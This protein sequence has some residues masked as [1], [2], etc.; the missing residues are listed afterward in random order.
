[1]ARLNGILETALDVDDLGATVDFYHG[2]LGLEV[3]DR[4]ERLC[5]L[6]VADR[7][8]LLSF[9]REVAAKAVELPGGVIPAHGSR[10][11]IHFAF[12]IDQSELTAWEEL[13]TSKGIAVESRVR[14]DRGGTSLYFRDPDGHLVEIATPG[15]WSIY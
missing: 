14:W 13:L 12:A 6:S 10:G 8:V 1:M 5:A 9:Q 2:K 11:S 7:D 15:I 4:S 3:I